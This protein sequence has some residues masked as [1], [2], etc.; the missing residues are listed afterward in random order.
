MT[1]A[2]FRRGSLT[3]MGQEGSKSVPATSEPP[4]TA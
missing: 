3:R 1:W 4:L 2:D